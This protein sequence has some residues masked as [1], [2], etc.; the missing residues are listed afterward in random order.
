MQG[1]R[2][3]GGFEVSVRWQDGRLASAEI[4]SLRDG[5]CRVRCS[6]RFDVRLDGAPVEVRWEEDG[7]AGFRCLAGLTYELRALEGAS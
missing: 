5:L 4:R 2:A 7:V 3:R 6:D 1:L